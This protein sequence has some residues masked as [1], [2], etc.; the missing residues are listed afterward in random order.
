MSVMPWVMRPYST[1]DEGFVV[2]SWLKSFSRSRIGRAWVQAEGW[3]GYW[4]GHRP[5]V[6]RVV[7]RTQI[8]CMPDSSDVILGWV[9]GTDE[10]LHYALCKRTLHEERL[11]AEAF[12]FMLGD[13]LN[14][15]QTLTH[16]QCDLQDVRESIT[17]PRMW[18]LNPYRLL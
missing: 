5:H 1:S 2:Y 17:P 15:A 11:A 8:L 3:S 14:R 6:L 10:L 13:R 4:A 16:E 9:A 7:H 12:C 18:T